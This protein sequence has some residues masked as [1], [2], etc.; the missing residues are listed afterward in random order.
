MSSSTAIYDACVL[1]PAPLRD[2]LMQL[3][4]TDLYKARW[5]NEIHDEW[6]RNCL[7]NQPTIQPERLERTRS[8]MNTHVRDCLVDGY[9]H[10]IDSLQLPDTNDRHVLAA[11]ITCGADIIITFNLK[12]FPSSSLSL[13]NIEAQ[14]PDMFI[15]SLFDLD[16]PLV[17]KAVNTVYNRLKNPPLS[18]EQYL[19][20]LLRQQLPKTISLL[21]E[22]WY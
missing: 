8:L 20:N 17:C 2:L 12:D 19:E 14:H 7:A 5:T 9:Q 6:I 16:T 11:A 15:S 22:F 10:L 21:K 1:Y 4:L 18:K 13:Y 3:A